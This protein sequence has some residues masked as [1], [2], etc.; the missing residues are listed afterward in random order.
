LT[1]GYFPRS[2]ID[3]IG[4]HAVTVCGWSGFQ[5]PNVESMVEIGLY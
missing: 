5:L 2:A 3:N 4:L 1:N